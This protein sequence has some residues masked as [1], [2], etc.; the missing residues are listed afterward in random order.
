MADALQSFEPIFAPGNGATV[1]AALPVD[2]GICEVSRILLTWPAGCGG[3]VG[4]Q[5]QAAGGFAFPS[6]QNQFMAFDDYTYDLEVTNQ[7]TS[8]KWSIVGYNTDYIAHLV[9]VV[10]E[11]DYLRGN[12]IGRASQPIAI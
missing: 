2:L 12:V 9:T 6:K 8:G 7:T 11:Y 5:I 3:L 10:F 1:I 4:V